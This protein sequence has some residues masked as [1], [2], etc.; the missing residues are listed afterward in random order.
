MNALLR[1]KK[2]AC[3]GAVLCTL[4][5]GTAFP[6]IKFGYNLMAIPENDVASKL[7]YAGLRFAIGGIMVY[8]IGSFVHK[9]P[10]TIKKHD[11]M[12]ILLLAIVQTALQYLFSYIGVGYTTAS[13]TSIITACMSFFV[14]LF[15]PIFF[16]NDKLTPLKIVGCVVGFAGVLAINFA[17]ISGGSFSF[18]GE[19]FVLFSTLCAAGGN[20][21]TKGVM[22]DR[23]PLSITAFQLTIGGILL[24]VSGL[25][26]GGKINLSTPLNILVLLYLALVS[27]IA[28]TLWTAILRYHKV[29]KISVFNLLVPVF[30]TIWSGILLGENVYKLENIIALL[31]VCVGIVVVNISADEKNKKRNSDYMEIKGIVFDM[32]GVLLD[33]EKLYV[34]FWCMGAKACGYNMEQC[35]ALSI[36]SMARPYAIERLKGYFGEDFDYYK[37]HKKRVE[38]MDKYIEENG[39]ETKPYAKETLE[40]LKNNNYKIALAT[41]TGLEKT[42]K[43][44]KQTG[45]YKYFDEIVCASMVEK[46]KPQPDIYIKAAELL[47]LEPKQCM[48]VEDSPNGVKSASLAGCVTIMVPD[49]DLPNEETRNKA[50]A[51]ADSLSD[52]PKYLKKIQ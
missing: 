27:A 44:L 10:M 19:G 15:A 8:I 20:L 33:T 22:K 1:N 16:K 4:L 45:L 46:G 50:F 51:V 31:L 2:F 42:E 34:H 9:K 43:Y 52:I 3:I 13:N 5:W 11:A 12:P 32:D 17:G 24:L 35:H 23:D 40:Y 14:V 29:S 30:G 7:V 41:A 26:L 28:F 36:R 18:L 47:N 39:I 6:V 21:L 25:V 49:L 48:A 38:L 37:V